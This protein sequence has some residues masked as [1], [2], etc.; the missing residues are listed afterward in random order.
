M[1]RKHLGS[2]CRLSRTADCCFCVL[3]Q[4]YTPLE[5]DHFRPKHA[6]LA[7]LS[8]SLAGS[9]FRSS[10]GTVA[11]GI[12]G[13]DSDAT[14]SAVGGLG[15]ARDDAGAGWMPER[16]SAVDDLHCAR[17]DCWRIAFL[18]RNRNRTMAVLRLSHVL[19]N[20]TNQLT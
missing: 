2:I 12:R 10:F 9:F 14:S 16:N 4:K 19:Q 13:S 3:W 5:L 17:C 1:L 20:R 11:F 6:S 18:Y 8:R 7:L 15:R